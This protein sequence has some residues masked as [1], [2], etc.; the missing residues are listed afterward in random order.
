[1]F[2]EQLTKSLTLHLTKCLSKG[3]RRSFFVS[4]QVYH[5]PSSSESTSSRYYFGLIFKKIAYIRKQY[6]NIEEKEMGMNIK[7]IYT[8]RLVLIPITY[9]IINSLINKD[10]LKIENVDLKI[11][12]S[13]PT[14]DTMDI[15]PIFKAQLKDSRVITGFEMWVIVK[16]ESSIIIGDIGFKGQPNEKG[17][18]E[19]GYGLVKEERKK[20]YGSEAVKAMVEWALNNDTVQ[21][22][23]ADCLINNIPS[24]KILEKIGMTEIMRD[25][26]L[27]Y[28][29]LRKS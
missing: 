14:D 15:L 28:W 16:E 21:C 2:L 17:E 24:S 19:I 29:E 10:P 22:I 26:D 13:W 5:I 20:G 3:A 25:K 27:I 1:M 23:K 8:D 4:V 6:I 7:K 18:V 11:N 9:E 12:E